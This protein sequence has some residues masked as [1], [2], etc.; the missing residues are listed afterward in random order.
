[1][2]LKILGSSSAGNCY[3]LESSSDSLLIEAGVRV[4]KMLAALNYD[5]PRVAGCLVSHAHG[6]H[7]KSV[8]EVIYRGINTYSLQYTFDK[9]KIGEHWR[10]KAITPGKGLIIG[11]FKVYPFSVSHDIPCLGFLITH[12]ECGSVLFLTDTYTCD[13]TFKGVNHILI[14]ANYSDAI[15]N[16]NIDAGRMPRSMIGR[17]LFSHMELEAT[18]R[19]VSEHNSDS[20]K[21]ITLIHLSNENSNEKQ[22]SREIQSITGKPVYVAGA[23]LTI[24]LNN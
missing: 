2:T 3:I 23:G 6:D 8:A 19:I 9:L 1:M 7:A 15:L 10:A 14:E 5:L 13:Y 21:S 20:L 11:T 16:A 12:S 17:L 18:K 4:S 22:F 24:E